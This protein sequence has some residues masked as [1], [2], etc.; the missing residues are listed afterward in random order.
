[1]LIPKRCPLCEEPGPAP[2]AGC[3]ADLRHAGAMAPVVG[4]DTLGALFAYEG[5]VRSLLLKLKYGNRRDAVGWLGEQLAARTPASVVADVVT[6]AP[7][8][9]DRAGRR[10]YDQ[11]ELLARAVARSSGLPVRPLLRRQR[12]P[13]QTGLAAAQRHQAPRFM[14]RRPAPAAVLLV[15]DVATTGSTL[16]AA[17]GA[18]R[19]A[20]AVQVHAVV[21]ARTPRTGS[22]R[23]VA[24]F[25]PNAH[26]PW[27]G[28]ACRSPSAAAKR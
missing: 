8:S 23:D 3:V 27:G 4:L 18:L 9:G 1:M 22:P 14:A 15:D 5:A 21:V 17:A 20:G 26:D 7:T 2:C 6:W 13:A 10:G 25:G 16:A 11:A 28:P 19:R 12:G 24:V